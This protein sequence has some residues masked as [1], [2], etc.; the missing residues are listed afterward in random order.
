M[1]VQAVVI[2]AAIAAVLLAFM[3]RLA[4]WLDHWE[5]RRRREQ[6][7]RA[8]ALIRS[9]GEEDHNPGGPLTEKQARKLLEDILQAAIR[10]KADAILIDALAGRPQVRLRLEGKYQELTGV[11]DVESFRRLVA[12]ARSGAGLVAGPEAGPGGQGSFSRLYR[13]PHLETEKWRRGDGEDSFSYYERSRKGRAV[14]FDLESYPAPGGEA[15]K[16]LLRSEIASESTRFDLGFAREAEERFIRAARSRSGIV[17]LTGPCNAGKSTATYNILSLLRDEGRRVATVEWPAERTLRGVEQNDL[18][19]G[20]DAYDR[21]GPCLRQVVQG[22]TDVLLLQN[23]D[24]VND[25]DAQAAIDFAAAGGLLV[26]AVHLR[27][28]ALGAASLL[29]WHFY[30]RR[31]QIADLLRI[32]VAP[33]RLFM[34]CTHCAEEYRVP[35]RVFLES[36]MSDPPIGADGR[37]ST[38]RGRGCP[39]CGNTGELGSIAVYEVLDLM[40]EMRRFIENDNHWDWG[41]VDYLRRQAWLHGM[42]T[43]RELALERVLAGDISLRHALLNTSKPQWLVE[44]QAARARRAQGS[45]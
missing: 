35:A 4:H 21:V 13:K 42:R 33:R 24:W 29:A 10:Q 17:L 25:E 43:Q 19:D 8:R 36:G 7:A 1:A 15:L 22:G 44:A 32:I 5:D 34:A 41:Q 31:R 26:T 27:D 11:G 9:A 30:P 14:R 3:I 28:C 2:V 16:I 23:I 18:G 39:M 12:A 38:W 20:L 6:L 45:T 40:G 37:V